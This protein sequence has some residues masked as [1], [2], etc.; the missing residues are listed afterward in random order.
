MR[1]KLFKL[2]KIIALPADLTEQ[3]L[4]AFSKAQQHNKGQ[5]NDKT[6]QS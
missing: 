4:I 3:L 1:A 2:S 6:A 5:I